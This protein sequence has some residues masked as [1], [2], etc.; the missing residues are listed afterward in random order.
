[1]YLF[2]DAVVADKHLLR[3][4]IFIKELQDTALLIYSIKLVSITPYL[5]LSGAWFQ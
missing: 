3:F 4:L 2:I 5:N 1:M